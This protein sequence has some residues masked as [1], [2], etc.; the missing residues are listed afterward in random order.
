MANRAHSSQ[1]LH[2]CIV[3]AKQ[4]HHWHLLGPARPHV[5]ARP[6]QAVVH[7]QLLKH[8]MFVGEVREQAQRAH[9]CLQERW[10][11]RRS[12]HAWGQ[13]HKVA[14]GGSVYLLLK[15]CMFARW[16]R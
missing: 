7:L 8:C 4:P 5:I 16:A 9:T 2:T 3:D 1:A 11:S 12:E 10:G 14:M 13:R 15:H 6:L